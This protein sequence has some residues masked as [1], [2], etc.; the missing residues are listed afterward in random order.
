VDQVTLQTIG[1]TK[2][3]PE[4]ST[5]IEGGGD[6]DLLNSRLSVG[7]TFYRKTRV[8]ALMPRPLPPSVYGEATVLENIGTIRNTGFELTLGAELVRTDLVTWRTGV[9]MSQDRNVIVSLGRG[10]EPFFTA[11]GSNGYY[12]APGYPLFGRWA[13]PILGYADANA[14]GVIDPD[15][16][17]LGDT[18][19]YA[20]ETMPNYTA[21]LHS[22]LSFFRGALSVDAALQYQD[23]LTQLNGVAM[24]SNLFSRGRN[25]VNAPF[26]EQAASVAATTYGYLQTVST[27]RFNSL[28]V[29]YHTSP[30]LSRRLGCSALSVALQGTNLGLRTNYRGLDPNV[31]SSP[32]GNGMSDGG[33]LPQPRTWQLRVSVTY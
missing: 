33:V 1:N 30:S 10:V 28:S 29:A 20:G 26:G 18:A 19:V 9:S 8:D 2:L 16:V 3:K 12:I 23:G 32:V 6:A 21:T 25:D 13:K 14:N 7:V 4:R 5:E 27:L 24:K 17:L 15:E 11:Q 31:N 22:T